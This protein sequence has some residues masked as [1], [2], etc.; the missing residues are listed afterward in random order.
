MR[1]VAKTVNF[2]I[3]YGQGAFGLAAQLEI[4]R[5]EA[6]SIIDTYFEK[7]PN[8]KKFIESTVAS[9]KQHGYAETL[10]GRRRYFPDINSQNHTIRTATERAAVNMPIQGTAADMMKV[11]M[12][13]IHNTMKEQNIKSKLMLQVHDELVFEV[14][15]EELETLPTLIKSIMETAFPLPH[16]PVIAESGIG[17]SWYEAH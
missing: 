10:A 16:V 12:I 15:P 9:T 11:A 5:N 3:M 8:I 17:N 13:K 7:Y 6:K 14:I 4:P 2:G 1:R